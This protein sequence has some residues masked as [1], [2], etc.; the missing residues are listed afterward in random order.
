MLFSPSIS[1]GVS[2]AS[3]SRDPPVQSRGSAQGR[4]TEHPTECPVCSIVLEMIAVIIVI[5]VKKKPN[6]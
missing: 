3:A 6:I 4:S 5:L 1:V 2:Y